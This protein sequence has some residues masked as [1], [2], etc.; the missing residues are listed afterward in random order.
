M[1]YC[2]D[3]KVLTNRRISPDYFILE[4][5][6]AEKLPNIQA[7]QFVE[8][9]VGNSQ[10]TFLRRPFSIHDVDYDANSISLLIR[11]LGDGT[12]RLSEIERGEIIN[13]VY[14]LGKGFTLKSDSRVLLVG[15]GCG[16]AP[17]LYLAKELNKRNNEMSVLLGSQTATDLNSINSFRE[18]E[19]VYYATDDGSAGFHGFVTNHPIFANST[20]DFIYTCGPVIMMREI[21][22]IAKSK[23]VGCEVSLENTMACGVGAC[24]CCVT[25][26][27]NGNECVCTEGPVFNINQ[28]R[29]E[30]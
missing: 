14:P 17:L 4:I 11:I 21:A 25:E 30:I 7:G 24:L 16:V 18:F 9:L 19:N 13:T 28:L 23:N 15:G 2:K 26:T 20:F 22:R 1:K 10:K 27:V 5:A 12:K 6:D 3:L 8:C 29:W